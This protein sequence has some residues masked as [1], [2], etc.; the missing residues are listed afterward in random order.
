MAQTLVKISKKKRESYEWSEWGHD[1]LIARKYLRIRNVGC[2]RPRRRIVR[3]HIM[4]FLAEHVEPEEFSE[5]IILADWPDYDIYYRG[6]PHLKNRGGRRISLR[7]MID[8]ITYLE[9]G[10]V[11]VATVYSLPEVEYPWGYRILREDD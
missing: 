9:P 10:E 8:G 4:R 7:E 11:A 5:L 6:D 1:A 2:I 3:K